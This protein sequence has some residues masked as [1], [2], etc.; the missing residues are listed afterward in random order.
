MSV[1]TRRIDVGGGKREKRWVC[2]Q[3]TVMEGKKGETKE[4]YI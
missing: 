2:I 1:K 3:R 4:M